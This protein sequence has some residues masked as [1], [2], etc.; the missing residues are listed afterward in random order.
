MADTSARSRTRSRRR[1]GRTRTRRVLGRVLTIVLSAGVLAAVPQNPAAAETITS[2]G[3]LSSIEITPD[4]NC[5][6]RYVGDDAA[7]F[8]GETACATLVAVG[9]TLYGP[10]SIP[11]GGSASP[12]EA[13]TP[14]SQTGPTGTGTAADPFRIVTVVDLG[15]S[16]VRLTETDVYRSGGESYT[17]TVRLT[18][19][20]G[21]SRDARVYRAADCYIAN[22][23]FG[24]GRVTEGA[25]ACV[26]ASESDRVAQWIPVT[27]GSHYYEASY[28]EVWARIG[29]QLPFPDTCRCNEEIDNGAGLSW[30]V[31]VPA[32]GAA[33]V[34]HLTAFSPDVEQTDRD[35]DGLLDV[36]ETDG[37]DA[38]ADGVVDVDLPAMGA[39]P[40]HKDLFVEIDWMARQAGCIWV[41]CWG[42]KDFSPNQD[43]V[44]DAV[45]TMAAAPVP[46]PD[47]ASGIRLHVDAG[48]GSVMNPVTGGTWGARS[49][50]NAVPWQSSLGSFNGA[51]EY[52]WGEF[53][54]LR[55]TH[56]QQARRDIFHYT[57]FADTYGGSGSSGIAQVTS[58]NFEGDSFLVTDGAS[59]W[60][61]GGF[62]RRQEAGTF[63]HEF[64]HTL[65]LRHGGVDNTNYKPNYL[66]IMSYYWQLG[67][68]PL[69][70]SRSRLATLDETALVEADGLPGATGNFGW[71]CAGSRRTSAN[72]GQ[73]DWNCNGTIGAGS[74]NQDVND[75]GGTGSLRGH[76]DW[77][78]IVYDGGAVGAFGAGD[79][80]DQN[81]PIESTPHDEPTAAELRAVDAF[82]SEG[83]GS[84]A[85]VGPSV[86]L[87][88]IEGQQLLVDVQNVGAVPADYTLRLR[89]VPGVAGQV[90][91]ADVAAYDDARVPVPVD[92]DALTPGTYE[93]VATL[94]RPGQNAPLATSTLEVVVPDLTDEDQQAQLESALERLQNPQ[95]GLPEDVRRLIVSTLEAAGTTLVNQTPP[96][97]TAPQV[98]RTV[99]ATPGTWSEDGADFAYRWMLDGSPLAGATDPS[100][101][102]RRSMAGQD[103]A[104]EV[105]A[106]LDGASATAES[107]VQ[108]VA[109]GWIVVRRDPRIV[110]E[111]RV[112]GQVVARVGRTVPRA[113]LSFQWLRN[114]YEV[115]GQT[116]DWYRMRRRD[117]GAE[118]VVRV[119][120]AKR[121]FATRTLSSNP[122]VVRR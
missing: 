56:L 30:D 11:A 7:E 83:D 16:G 97:F 9:G 122:R 44:N 22:S 121:G 70:Y 8:Y 67:S 78:N 62:T 80:N 59:G 26:S 15:D 2:P 95:P 52:Q 46:N 61:A 54:A 101:K 65:S 68:R 109:P 93:L 63:L 32:G 49:R 117:A 116:R 24:L 102:I 88:G 99:T 14:V 28:H 96:E 6:V 111:A 23:D 48:P 112:G 120:Y 4:L 104:V 87:A 89:G 71:F 51:G 45:A 47:G 50:A 25:V 55:D 73:V 10:A 27:P 20:G 60:G 66:S 91:V 18:H 118:L 94:T 37:Y 75:D 29:A 72:A 39:D 21:G 31:T 105:T 43:A 92:D 77:A 17:T 33:Q 119:T 85:V 5:D 100:L 34:T 108:E 41:I 53:N 69:D 64:G 76:D 84:V 106:T 57:I 74:L 79:L 38:D 58:A 82:G 115:R 103:L 114:G 42:A 35:G 81:P 19:T 110:G 36:W 113:N 90:A 12:R 107:A 3:P 40:D 1:G 86:L 98:G 13:F